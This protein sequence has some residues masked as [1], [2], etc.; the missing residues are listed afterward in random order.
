MQ[1]AK[2]RYLKS[3][4]LGFNASELKAVKV[5]LTIH[6]AQIDIC[7]LAEFTTAFDEQEKR[8]AQGNFY[9]RDGDL[10][11]SERIAA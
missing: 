11:V 7:T 5:A 8:I 3:Q 4:S 6:Q 10:S 9:K 2:Q 1:E